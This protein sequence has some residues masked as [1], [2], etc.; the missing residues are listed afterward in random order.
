M[1][2][3]KRDDGAGRG[4]NGEDEVDRVEEM[5]PVVLVVSRGQSRNIIDKLGCLPI[6]QFTILLVKRRS[7]FTVPTFSFCIACV[8]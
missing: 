1:T 6:S 7:C 8:S 2:R 4:D 5:V 3:K